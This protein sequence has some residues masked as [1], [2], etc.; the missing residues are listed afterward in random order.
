[1]NL[2]ILDDILYGN[3]AVSNLHLILLNYELQPSWVLKAFVRVAK[4]VTCADGGF[5]RLLQRLSV[6]E[7]RGLPDMSKLVIGDGD[8]L[9]P[10]SSSTLRLL[11]ECGFRFI[12]VE[13]EDTTDFTKSWDY[14]IKNKIIESPKELVN[15]CGLQ[16]CPGNSRRRLWRPF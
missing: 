1:M 2:A 13:N 4:S 9:F 10:N 15:N 8:S 5:H 3:G 11:E 7:L 16:L 14:L 6:E 12:Q